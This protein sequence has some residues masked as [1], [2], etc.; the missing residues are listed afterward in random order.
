MQSAIN[1]CVLTLKRTV[2]FSVGRFGGGGGGGD[3][4]VDSYAASEVDSHGSMAVSLSSTQVSVKEDGTTP[5]NTDKGN[6]QYV[7][8]DAVKKLRQNYIINKV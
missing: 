1:S 8:I 5:S 4:R 6:S 2:V 3:E 7:G